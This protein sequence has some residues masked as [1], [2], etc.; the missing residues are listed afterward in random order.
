VNLGVVV[1]HPR[2]RRLKKQCNPEYIS[3]FPPAFAF[4]S[5]SLERGGAK[6]KAG[7]ATLLSS[8]SRALPSVFKQQILRKS[9]YG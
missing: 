1:W 7:G 9:L 3:T 2:I 5:P 8:P 6:V 4:A